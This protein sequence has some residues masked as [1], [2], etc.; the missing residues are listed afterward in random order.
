MSSYPLFTFETIHNLYHGISKLLKKCSVYYLS[1][2]K[3]GA[4][5][6][7]KRKDSFIKDQSCLL[8]GYNL[9]L[10]VIKESSERSYKL[11]KSRVRWM[12][13]NIYKNWT[14]WNAEMDGL[15]S[16]RRNDSISSI[17]HWSDHGTWKDS[18][19]DRGP[20][21]VQRECCWCG[22]IHKAAGMKQ[23]KV[24]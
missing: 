4:G 17:V 21:E 6:A 10:S 23:G 19:Y 20:Y 13:R 14:T 9:L 7:Q 2:N 16:I 1:Y 18:T 3:L 24:R 8:S 5:E 12:R 11:F 22:G 15:P